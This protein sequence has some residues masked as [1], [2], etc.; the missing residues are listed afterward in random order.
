MSD[1]TH[2]TG[3]PHQVPPAVPGDF[4]PATP[5]AHSN[6]EFGGHPDHGVG[7]VVSMK[8]LGTVFGALV[9]LTVITVAASYV[10]F[11][12]ANLIVALAIAVLKATLVVL[13]FMH[14][15]WDKPFNS[16][17]FVGCLIFVALFISLAMLDT[18]QYHRTVWDQQ[19]P[20]INHKKL[21]TAE[22][23][24]GAVERTGVPAVGESG[25]R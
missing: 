17:V 25:K 1:I 14:L 12:E 5:P 22:G 9:L 23:E 3:H 7:H 11:G 21:L 13:Y 19:A 24:A 18:G 2:D 6:E 20:K 15:R 8:V 10:N 16:I 4:A